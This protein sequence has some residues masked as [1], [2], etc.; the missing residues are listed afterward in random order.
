MIKETLLHLLKTR[1]YTFNMVSS[2]LISCVGDGIAQALEQRGRDTPFHFDGLRSFIITSWSSAVLAP[3]YTK[4]YAVLDR[5]LP[6]RSVPHIGIKVCITAIVC[7]P[8]FNGLYL[9]LSTWGED[10]LGPS[11]SPTTVIME[12]CQLK[13]RHE[14]PD[15]VLSSAKLWVP[16]NSLNWMFF[17]T[18]LR[19]LVSTCVSVG[20]NAY[21]S[22]VGHRALPTPREPR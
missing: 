11:P 17:P 3:F 2:A 15:L 4:Y 14:L 18:H 19:V 16:V 13:V 7:A 1:P 5:F 22:L 8:V 12:R 9:S 20:W 21:L 6:L 10:R